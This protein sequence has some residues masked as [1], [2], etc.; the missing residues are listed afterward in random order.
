[1]YKVLPYVL[2]LERY[3]RVKKTHHFLTIFRLI[4]YSGRHFSSHVINYILLSGAEVRANQDG[5]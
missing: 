2:K 5:A 3:S 4:K 1:M